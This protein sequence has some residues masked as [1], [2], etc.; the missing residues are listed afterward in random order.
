MELRQLRHLVAVAEELHFARAAERLGMEQS[1]LSHSI[2]NLEADLKIKLFHRTTRRTWLTRA[3]TRF[4]G[5]AKRIL[6]DIDSARASLHAGVDEPLAPAR[7]SNAA[8]VEDGCDA[9]QAGNAS[10]SDPLNDGR[11]FSAKGRASSATLAEPIAGASAR[12]VRF[13][14]SAPCFSR[15][16]VA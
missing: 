7:R 10:S 4:F 14:S 11:T 16:Q 5:E 9:A 2:G 6:A 15:A 8:G 1:T 3:G 12:L 13:P